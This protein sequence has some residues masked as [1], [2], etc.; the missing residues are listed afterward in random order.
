MRMLRDEPGR[1]RASHGRRTSSSSA[2]RT[3]SGVQNLTQ[4]RP[5]RCRV[6]D[7]AGERFSLAVAVF[8]TVNT[9]RKTQR[10]VIVPLANAL[11]AAPAL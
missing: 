5:K 6:T 1:Q 9:T 3:S 4:I 10:S 11:P 8:V 7:T 2:G